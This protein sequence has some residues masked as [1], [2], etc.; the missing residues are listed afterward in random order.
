MGGDVTPGKCYEIE[1]VAGAAGISHP[2]A[3]DEQH[4]DDQDNTFGK[5][6]TSWAMGRMVNAGEKVHIRNRQ[7]FSQQKPAQHQ[8]HNHTSNHGE[9]IVDEVVQETL[10]FGERHRSLAAESVE[11][12][13]L[14]GDVRCFQMAETPIAAFL[15]SASAGQ[16]HS[17]LVGG[18]SPRA[19]PY[20]VVP[21]SASDE[22]DTTQTPSLIRTLFHTIVVKEGNKMFL[23]V[24]VL[25]VLITIVRALLVNQSDLGATS[26]RGLS[27]DDW[28]SSILLPVTTACLFFLPLALP[29]ALILAE[30]LATASVLAN[31]EI[32]LRPPAVI[33]KASTASGVES[34][35]SSGGADNA[36]GNTQPLLGSNTAAGAR[37][38]SRNGSHGSES[39]AQQRR[40][41]NDEDDEPEMEDEFM[42]E[43][44]D[45]RAE[46]I[47]ESIS[48]QV[49]WSRFFGYL[50]RVLWHR[51]FLGLYPSAKETC[52]KCC[53][54]G[55]NCSCTSTGAAADGDEDGAYLPIPLARS[56]LLEVLGAVTMVCFVDDDV[57]CEGYSVTEE[58][59][60]LMDNPQIGDTAQSS[61]KHK[62][63]SA[64]QQQQRGGAG[65]ISN[66]NRGGSTTDEAEGAGGAT[67]LPAAAGM[68]NINKPVTSSA[69]V[70]GIVLDLHANPE[71]TG[72]R[73][74]NPQWWRY[75]PSL[76]P[77]GLNAMLTYN[78]TAAETES[79]QRQTSSGDGNHAISGAAHHNHRSNSSHLPYP[80]AVQ[81][82]AQDGNGSSDHNPLVLSQAAQ[83]QQQNQH[84]QTERSLVR[85]I[86][87]L[88]P[89]ESLR[90]LA[91]EI[92]FEQSDL[93]A[94]SRV[95]EV[96]V[97][98]PGLEN[99]HLL[100][101]TH[102]WGQEE[103]RR[104]G[105]LL[106][107]LRGGVYKDFRDGSLQ[108]MLLGDPSL[109]LNYC[110]EYWDGST[111]SI[112]PLSSAD[113]AEVL[114]VYERWRLEDFEVV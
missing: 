64:S 47:A 62:S 101:D 34:L 80:S 24:G 111:R 86:R 102:Q 12:L 51:L 32:T 35:G 27:Y 4:L 108:M 99:A 75:L 105:S 55:V 83:Q 3:N 17:S 109:V 25:T 46:D 39:S 26:Y 67:D 28:V 84:Q 49:R 20:S 71:A 68:G 87:H 78:Y 2:T 104:R 61:Q 5:N 100:E 42:D 63:S 45:E 52:C 37:D 11:I 74:E 31:A 43:D 85:H 15:Q 112:T 56:R 92:G 93:S 41:T 14:C 1:R 96:N 79:A 60:L 77:L 21:A 30:A 66:R 107:Q 38:K 94:F 48:T 29:V 106:P 8:Q 7:Q 50:G 97:L 18:G 98:A 95:L 13:G 19:G 82:S 16:A 88:L 22:M 58:I 10:H 114:N 9:G 103:S 81:R 57:I 91:E 70:K 65:N 69:A 54:S 76:K 44:I 6:P 90:E 113:R 110:R 33:K 59:F 72:S 89:P 40:N 23:A 53:A 36:M 73:F